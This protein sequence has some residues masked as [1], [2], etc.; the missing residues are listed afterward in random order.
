M[1]SFFTYESV[2]ELLVYSCFG[3]L[4]GTSIYC[5]TYA[6]SSIIKCIVR[7]LKKKWKK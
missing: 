2:K 7:T 5:I 1:E 6:V 3:I 4:L